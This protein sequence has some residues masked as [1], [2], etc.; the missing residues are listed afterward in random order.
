MGELAEAHSEATDPDVLPIRTR[1]IG[2]AAGGGATVYDETET[3]SL[4]FRADWL[5]RQNLDASH[6]DI[7]SVR[8]ESMEP[9]LP[10]G[11]SILVD[12]GRQR[13][14]NGHIY[15]LYTEDGLVVKR[16]AHEGAQWQLRSEHPAYEPTPMAESDE[17]IGEVRW[18]AYTLGR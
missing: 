13:R 1:E 3:G 9:V 7:I 17:V 5:R 10:D 2:A 14:L 11:C 18:A 15:A 8:G 6:C 12:R 4:W 16:L